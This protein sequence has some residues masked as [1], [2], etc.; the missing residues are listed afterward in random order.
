LRAH[1][2]LASLHYYNGDITGAL[3]VLDTA[4]RRVDES[5]L[6]WSPSGVEI[7]ILEVTARYVAGDLA[8]SVTAAALFTAPGAPAATPPDVPAARLAAV[9][10]YPAVARGEADVEQRFA[11]LREVWDRDAQ[12][13]LVAG[14]CEADH[15]LWAENPLAA[16]EMAE[17]AQRFLDDMLG[18]GMYGGLW[19]SALG[20]AAL[21]DHAAHSRRRRDAAAETDARLRGD[22]LLDRV[23]RLTA[24]G[25]GRPG[26]LGPEGR[27][28]A[29]RATAEHARLHG[30]AT[31][32]QWGAAVDAFGFGYRYEQARCR[33]RLAESLLEN[34][35]RRGAEVAARAALSDA[36]D[37]GAE[38]LR[39]AVHKFL[40]SGRFDAATSGG[41]LTT[42]ELE[43][44]AL[45][46]EGLTNRQIGQRL[47][48]SEKTASVHL[49]NLMAKLGVS[50]RTEAVTVAARRGLLDVVRP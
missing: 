33:W 29:V 3:P 49:S 26:G 31:P 41:P 25:Y 39:R 30:T 1:Y 28:W 5:G 21:A 35:D 9:S 23:E 6:R 24:S 4:L 48:I 2:Y 50:G 14:G 38:P 17:R 27:A 8:G 44:L 20:L 42:R 36:A 43:V 16:V 22:V 46:A 32:D 12:I 37:M 10:C 45:V 11:A 13:G 7:R 15:L 47:F 40:E 18:P 19:L 34:G